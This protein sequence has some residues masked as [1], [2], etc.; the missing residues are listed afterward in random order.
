M[1]F[2]LYILFI[3]NEGIA[4]FATAL[5]NCWLGLDFFWVEQ[6][7]GVWSVD[8]FLFLNHFQEDFT[9]PWFRSVCYRSSLRRCSVR[10][11]VHRNFSKFTGKHLHQSLFFNKVPGLRPVTFEKR[12]SGK[13]V[14]LWILRNFYEHLFK[15]HPP[16]GDCFLC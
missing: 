16:Q 3:W 7:T 11:G 9:F 4:K 13:G 2:S 6:K 10:K 14:F 1:F 12:G 8:M 15:E 5:Y